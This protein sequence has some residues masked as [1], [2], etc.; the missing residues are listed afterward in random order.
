M[1]DDDLRRLFESAVG[2]MRRHFDVSTEEVKRE[3]RIVAEGLARLDQKVD[4]T[5]AE[6]RDEMRRGFAVRRR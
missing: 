3:V 2:E 5:T 1:T 4:R 6:I